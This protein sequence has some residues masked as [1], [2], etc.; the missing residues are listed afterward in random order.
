MK[1][2]NV[3][4]VSTNKVIY[5]D[6]DMV[7]KVFDENYSKSD[8][9]NEALNH[10]RVEETGLNIPKI[11]EVG[12]VGDKW[13]IQM[14]YIQGKTL[15]QL[16]E[17]NP[18]KKKEYIDLLVDL[19]LEVIGKKSPLLKKLKDKMKTK[20]DQTDLDATTR[21][22]LHERL[23]GMPKHNKVCHGDFHP[24]NVIIRPDGSP[25]IIDWAHVTQGNASADAARTFLL[26]SLEGKTE[27]ANKYLNLFCKKSDTARQYVQKWTPIVAASQSVKGNADE[28]AMLKRWVNVVDYE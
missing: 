15:A 16:M 17:E 13:F 11:H 8:V 24:S 20:I 19:Q 7:Y 5:S 10:A 23:E 12:K 14:D 6:G 26:F 25:C 2:D 18:D 21:Y 27:L 3:L 28:F 4:V 9:L 22:E 1:L